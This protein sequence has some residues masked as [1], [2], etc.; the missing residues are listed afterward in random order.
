MH[1]ELDEVTMVTLTITDNGVPEGGDDTRGATLI[2]GR[3]IAVVT[4]L[5]NDDPHG[6]FLWSPAAID[7][8][9]LDNIFTVHILREFGDIGAVTLD[10]RYVLPWLPMGVFTL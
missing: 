5:A 4:V 6:V 3:G 2:G 9:E 10:Y 8:E 1:A 7:T